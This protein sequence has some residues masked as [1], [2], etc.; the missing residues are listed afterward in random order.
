MSLGYHDREDYLDWMYREKNP[1]F[2]RE[3]A[4][5]PD[6]EDPDR[7]PE[8]EAMVADVYAHDNARRREQNQ[9]STEALLRAEN[10]ELRALLAQHNIT[11]PPAR[12]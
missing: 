3:I 11:P 8:I 2:E 6:P 5:T 10:E 4:Y 12:H 7:D 1:G 9:R